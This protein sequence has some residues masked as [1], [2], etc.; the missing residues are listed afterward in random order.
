MIKVNSTDARKGLMKSKTSFGL[1]LNIFHTFF[2]V[3]IID[4][5][6]VN[7]A[8]GTCNHVELCYADTEYIFAKSY[9]TKVVSKTVA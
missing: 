8:G 4:F 2:I 7:F 6:Q 9:H 5:E 1:V 3:S